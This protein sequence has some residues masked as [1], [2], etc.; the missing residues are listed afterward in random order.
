MAA[1]CCQRLGDALI[2]PGRLHR[3]VTVLAPETDDAISAVQRHDL[4]DAC[5]EA[6]LRKLARLRRGTT[7]AVITGFVKEARSHNRPS[8]LS[9]VLDRRCPATTGLSADIRAIAPYEAGH[10]VMAHRLGQVVKSVLVVPKD[11]ADGVA[12]DDCERQDSFR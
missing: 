8:T 9:D 2:R 12:A 4:R 10:A 6:A 11:V 3:C 5:D 1:N 7:P